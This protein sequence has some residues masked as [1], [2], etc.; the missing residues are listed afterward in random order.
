MLFGY[1]HW[2]C[3]DITRLEEVAVICSEFNI[4]HLVNNAYGVQS[5]KC[6]HLIQQVWTSFHYCTY[7]LTYRLSEAH[8]FHVMWIICEIR[9]KVSPCDI[10]LCLSSVLD[11][12]VGVV[13]VCTPGIGPMCLERFEPYN[14]CWQYS[15]C[16]WWS[17][18]FSLAFVI[19]FHLD[20]WQGDW[21]S[22]VP[23]VWLD[24]ASWTSRVLV[25]ALTL[26]QPLKKHTWDQNL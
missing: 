13:P 24:C 11:S 23:S 6:M 20:K 18:W 8:V 4:P 25:C 10:I 7:C 22:N 15:E 1:Q 26:H 9:S 16:N 3:I 2:E 21:G 14:C 19:P 5:S 12:Q 17:V